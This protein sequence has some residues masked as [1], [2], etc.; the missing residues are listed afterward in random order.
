MHFTLMEPTL[1]CTAELIE[2]V[3]ITVAVAT[4]KVSMPRGH[5][6]GL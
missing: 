2:D 3:A 5:C 6:R 4:T 1:V